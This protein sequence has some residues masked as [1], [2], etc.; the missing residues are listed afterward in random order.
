MKKGNGNLKL[1]L[2]LLLIVVAFE[3]IFLISYAPFLH[4][5]PLSQPE[6]GECPAFI[7]ETALVT[8]SPLL[9]VVVF[10]LLVTILFEVVLFENKFS[11]EFVFHLSSPRSPPKIS[12]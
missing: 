9:L 12:I 6:T 7:I 10:I 2:V 11:S 3:F 5:H 1:I 8:P 4:N